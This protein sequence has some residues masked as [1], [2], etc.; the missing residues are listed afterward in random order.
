MK[1]KVGDIFYNINK[2]GYL[3]IIDIVTHTNDEDE[4]CYRVKGRTTG[5]SIWLED[6]QLDRY[7]TE[8]VLVLM[9]DCIGPIKWIK[10]WTLEEA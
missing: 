7:V 3:S 10:T 9:Q 6:W 8:E 1:Y 2:D 5:K 4:G